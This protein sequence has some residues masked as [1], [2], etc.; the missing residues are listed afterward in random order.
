[1][2]VLDSSAQPAAIV[3]ATTSNSLEASETLGLRYH[4]EALAMRNPYSSAECSMAPPHPK[5]SPRTSD[6][7]RNRMLINAKR[8][9]RQP[10]ANSAQGAICYY[11]QWHLGRLEL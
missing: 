11:M 9:T 3:F 8:G 4:D 6:L 10:S 1:M 2:L 5:A 7:R